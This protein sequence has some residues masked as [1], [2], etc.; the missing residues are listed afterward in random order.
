MERVQKFDYRHRLGA[1][2]LS[3]TA[4]VEQMTRRKSKRIYNEGLLKRLWLWRERRVSRRRRFDRS[5]VDLAGR[6]SRC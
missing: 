5:W 4:V 6:G 3:V 2:R 1:G